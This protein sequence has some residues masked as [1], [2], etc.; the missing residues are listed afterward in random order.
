MFRWSRKTY[1]EA[2]RLARVLRNYG[3]ATWPTPI[4]VKHYLQLWEEY[5]AIHQYDADPID[6]PLNQRLHWFKNPDLPF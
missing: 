6:A 4:P 3:D 2:A 1:R 5:E